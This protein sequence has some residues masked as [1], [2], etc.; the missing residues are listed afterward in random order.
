MGPLESPF[1]LSPIV[2]W[3]SLGN[4]KLKSD[5]EQKVLTRKAGW[6]DT[7]GFA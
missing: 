3:V 1:L 7:P 2:F 4:W 6:L 5:Q